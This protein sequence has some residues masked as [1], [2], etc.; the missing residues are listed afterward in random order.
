MIDKGM[1]AAVRRNPAPEAPIAAF[2]LAEPHDI[3][4]AKLLRSWDVLDGLKP[5]VIVQAVGG[6][7]PAGVTPRDILP[8]WPADGPWFIIEIV[9]VHEPASLAR[10]LDAIEAMRQR[11]PTWREVSWR[12]VFMPEPLSPS[13]VTRDAV[14]ALRADMVVVTAPGEQDVVASVFAG[15]YTRAQCIALDHLDVEN[16]C[17]VGTRGF[18]R[19]LV[20]PGIVDERHAPAVARW[21]DTL[22]DEGHAGGAAFLLQAVGDRRLPRYCEGMPGLQ[23]FHDFYTAVQTAV[24]LDG[25]ALTISTGGFNTALVVIAFV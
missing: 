11:Y 19:A 20:V 25:M 15:I 17:R 3:R 6:P 13:A 1:L 21:L 23:M 5:M 16:T 2:G 10:H 9:I 22:R 12:A 24:E 8:E 4:W 14:G 7:L 18:G